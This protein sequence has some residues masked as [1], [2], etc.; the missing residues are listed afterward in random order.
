MTR[1]PSRSRPTYTLLP[2]TTLCRS[3]RPG[4]VFGRLAERV[5]LFRSA[6][7]EGVAADAVAVTQD[8]VVLG[9][10]AFDIVAADVV[11]PLII[12][13]THLFIDSGNSAPVF[14]FV[15]EHAVAG[16]VECSDVQS[17]VRIVGMHKNW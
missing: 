1:R 10:G 3:V 12:Q 11:D 7:F 8:R 6:P 13:G 15:I 9:E 2:Y 16:T 4:P 5:V 17:L 14:G